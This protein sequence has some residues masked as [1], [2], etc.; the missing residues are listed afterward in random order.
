M[1]DIFRF[2]AI[3]MLVALIASGALAYINKITQPRIL[4]QQAKVL[5]DGLKAVLP[6]TESGVIEPVEVD[7]QVLYY[8]GYSDAG[9]TQLVGYALL[10]VGR[11]YSSDI[12]TIFGV[13]TTFAILSTKVLS[14][15]ET[16]GL[17]TLCEQIK[18]GDSTPWWQDQFRGKDLIQLSVDKDGGDIQSLTGATITSRA[19]TNS[20]AQ[21]LTWLQEQVAEQAE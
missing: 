6:G 19:I 18:Y 3:L 5:N 7:E 13:D 16:P 20:I 14:Q 21:S 15:N 2:A 1:K 12:R 9:K 8:K 17:G 11:G 4:E 10:A